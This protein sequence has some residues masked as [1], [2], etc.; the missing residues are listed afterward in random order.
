VVG[1]GVQE[2]QNAPV[3]YEVSAQANIFAFS[4]HTQFIGG[5]ACLIASQLAVVPQLLPS[6][7]QVITLPVVGKAGVV[8]E[9]VQEAQNAPV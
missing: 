8:G 4:Q 1:D 6:Q 5:V 9:G 7:F 3:Q 2:A